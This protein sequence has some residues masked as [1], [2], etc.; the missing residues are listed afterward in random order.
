MT[1]M[2]PR[3]NDVNIEYIYNSAINNQLTGA[4]NLIS[5]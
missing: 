3:M 4:V 1:D 5:N 2:N